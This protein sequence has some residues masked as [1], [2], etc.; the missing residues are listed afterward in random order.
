MG[1]NLQQA[2]FTVGGVFGGDQAEAVSL[3]RDIAK[4]QLGG[5]ADTLTLSGDAFAGAYNGDAGADALTFTTTQTVVVS[6]SMSGFETVSMA[7]ARMDVS[8]VLGAGGETLTFARGGQMLSIL[9]GGKLDGTVD[10]G[11]GDDVFNLAAGGQLVGTVLG[12]TG[13]DLVA[14]DLTSDLSLRGGFAPGRV[15]AAGFDRAGGRGT[16][17]VATCQPAHC[18]RLRRAACG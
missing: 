16:S 3:D 1:L 14:I 5:G 10:L 12:G 18:C 17:M 8:G 4:V 2:A 15:T 7:G 11:A 13:G 9:S 6:G